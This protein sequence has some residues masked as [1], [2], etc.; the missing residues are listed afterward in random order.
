MCVCGPRTIPVC[1]AVRRC[2][3]LDPCSALWEWCLV[4]RWS[5]PGGWSWQYSGGTP[6]SPGRSSRAHRWW[7]GAPSE[8]VCQGLGTHTDTQMHFINIKNTFIQTILN[9]I[10]HILQT[11]WGPSSQ[12]LDISNVHS[13]HLLYL[14][15]HWDTPQMNQENIYTKGLPAQNHFNHT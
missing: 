5:G 12:W 6:S 2:P 15:P 9:S 4:S 7:S 13:L 11:M 3:L 8:L 10:N 1:I 14:T